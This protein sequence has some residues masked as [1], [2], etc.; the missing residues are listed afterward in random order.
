MTEHDPKQLEGLVALLDHDGVD[1]AKAILDAG[2]RLEVNDERSESLIG[3]DPYAVPLSRLREDLHRYAVADEYAASHPFPITA[4]K[5]ELC[6]D[7]ERLSLLAIFFMN[8]CPMG[9]ED[10]NAIGG[11]QRA[12]DLLLL[13]LE[14]ECYRS[15]AL[16][17][18]QTEIKRAHVALDR[19][20]FSSGHV[21]TWED[22]TGVVPEAQDPAY[23][24]SYDDLGDDQTRPSDAEL[25]AA[26]VAWQAIEKGREQ[27][28]RD[29]LWALGFRPRPS[30]CERLDENTLLWTP[31]GPSYRDISMVREGGEPIKEQP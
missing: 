6:R 5:Q 4:S 19:D 29:A 8:R 20:P 11:I 14:T 23:T 30:I 24:V 25:A 13:E 12:F 16:T 31:G 22:K 26:R 15:V 7:L 3:Y 21:I 10:F 1:V 18:L 28:R 9:R 2:Y 27:D 17:R